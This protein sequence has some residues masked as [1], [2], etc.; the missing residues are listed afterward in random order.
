MMD[1]VTPFLKWFP[2]TGFTLSDT[3]GWPFSK[4]GMLGIATTYGILSPRF[5]ISAALTLKYRKA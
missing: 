4:S 1:M 5:L 3:T 2:G